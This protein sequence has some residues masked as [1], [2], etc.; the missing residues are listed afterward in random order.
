MMYGREG[1]TNSRSDPTLFLGNHLFH[2]RGNF[3]MFQHLTTFDLADQPLVVTHQRLDCFMHQR[4]SVASLLRG[5]TVKLGL[6]LWRK[7]YLHAVGVSAPPNSVKAFATNKQVGL[8][9]PLRGDRMKARRA[10]AVRY[11]GA[12]GTRSPATSFHACMAGAM[13]LRL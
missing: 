1:I 10:L 6:Q 12:Q 13:M 7:I 5:D 9:H 8:Q 11:A 4:F 3:L 2:T